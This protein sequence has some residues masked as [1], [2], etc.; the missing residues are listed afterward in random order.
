M[1]ARLIVEAIKR[2]KDPSAQGVIRGLESMQEFNLGGYTVDWS[3]TKHTGSSW[4]DL[5]IITASG[6]LLF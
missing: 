5:S 1:S 3:P 2:S 4:V 6:R